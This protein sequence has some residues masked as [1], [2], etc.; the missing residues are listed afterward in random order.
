MTPEPPS[1]PFAGGGRE[2]QV[3]WV[4]FPRPETTGDPLIDAI[5]AGIPAPGPGQTRVK[6]T[7]EL[8]LR[9]SEGPI[10]SQVGPMLDVFA[11]IARTANATHGLVFAMWDKPETEE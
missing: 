7:L 6:I 5:P 4:L 3:A 10:I 8:N 1:R 2:A 11:G 9:D